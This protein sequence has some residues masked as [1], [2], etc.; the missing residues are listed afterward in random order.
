MSTIPKTHLIS[1]FENQGSYEEIKTLEVEAPQITTGSDVI[2]KNKYAG[3]NFIDGYFRQG[4]YPST[5]RPYIFGREASGVV[6]AVGKDVTKFKV[7]DSVAYLSGN[8]FAQYTKIPETYTQILNLGSGS[9]S[10]KEYETYGG[11]FLQG[12]TA[13]T[14]VNDAY[15]VKK[16]DFILVWAAAGGVGTF[17]TQFAAQ[18]GANVIGVASTSEKLE[19]VKKLGAKYVINYKTEDVVARVKEITGG[20]GVIATFDS[21]GKASFETSLEALSRK[22][23]FVSYGNSSGVVPP[24]AITRLSP[25]NITLL[26][27]QLFGYIVEKDEWEHYSKFLVDSVKSGKV[28]FE[29]TKIYPLSEYAQAAKDLESGTTTG[30]LVVKIPQ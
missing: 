1:G 15:K 20:K 6:A 3:L 24:L 13:L 16:D 30:K 8:T 12:L 23:T 11:I 18:K 4:V 14:F 17:L 10:E 29:I 27:P 26:R 21:V 2:I 9:L 7:G 25:K 22:G 19:K 28:E 5:V